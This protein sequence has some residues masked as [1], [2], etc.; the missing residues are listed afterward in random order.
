MFDPTLPAN[1]SQIVSAELRNQFNGL[2]ELLDVEGAPPLVQVTADYDAQPG[3]RII[4]CNASV[5]ITVSL[6]P[7]GTDGLTRAVVVKNMS[8]HQVFVQGDQN[9][10]EPIDEG[11]YVTLGHSH[12]VRFQN[13]GVSNWYC[14]GQYKP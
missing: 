4:I 10:G 6:F 8:T 2:K 14:T 9:I 11:G 13:D 12:A 1:G 3:D 5:D 7:A